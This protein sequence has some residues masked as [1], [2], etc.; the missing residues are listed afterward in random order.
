MAASD[1]EPPASAAHA[2][3]GGSGGGLGGR[4]PLRGAVSLHDE[5]FAAPSKCLHADGLEY[6]WFRTVRRGCGWHPTSPGPRA[7]PAERS[8]HQP[9]AI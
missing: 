3:S 8:R 4:R 5:V 2:G 6:S 9:W 1:G 7:L